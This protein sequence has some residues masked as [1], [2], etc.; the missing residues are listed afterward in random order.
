MSL[1][2]EKQKGNVNTQQQKYNRYVISV[3]SHTTNYHYN[4]I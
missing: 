2:Q 4:K 3:V 1:L